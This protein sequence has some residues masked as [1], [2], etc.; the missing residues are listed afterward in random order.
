[1]VLEP[2]QMMVMGIFLMGPVR[3]RVL[4]PM[5]SMLQIVLKARPTTVAQPFRRILTERRT[6]LENKTQWLQN[7]RI[8]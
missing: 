4:K 5:M 3:D 1:M 8:F 7:S 2:D 6:R